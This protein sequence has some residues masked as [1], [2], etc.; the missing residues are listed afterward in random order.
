MTRF[1]SGKPQKLKSIDLRL[2][3]LELCGPQSVIN[4]GFLLGA[5]AGVRFNS[6]ILLRIDLDRIAELT[7]HDYCR[8]GK[9]VWFE[10]KLDAVSVFMSFCD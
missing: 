4:D 10:D 7:R 3:A 6:A 8:E 5:E 2:K 1:G 9:V